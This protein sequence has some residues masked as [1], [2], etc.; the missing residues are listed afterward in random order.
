MVHAA[1]HLGLPGLIVV[2][3]IVT[4]VVVKSAARKGIVIV[5]S[6]AVVV[7]QPISL[8][9]PVRTHG[10]FAATGCQCRCTSEVTTL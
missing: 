2:V 9:T 5:L 4:A 3:V 6:V 7:V 10:N 8:N 1:T